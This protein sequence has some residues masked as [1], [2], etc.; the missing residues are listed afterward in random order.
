MIGIEVR[1]LAGRFHA[2]AW[3][4]AHNEGIP[5]WP[6]SP[7]RVL[8]ALVHAACM[9][10]VPRERAEPLLARISEPPRYLL[11]RAVDAHTRHYMPDVARSDHET[12]R[13]FDT[14][15][16]VEGGAKEPSPLLVA[17]PV[18]L[19]A[20]ERALLVELCASV[21]YLGRAESWA[22]LRVV[23]VAEDAAW[24]CVPEPAAAAPHATTLLAPQSATGIAEWS[25]GRPRP[26]RGADVPRSL[27]D[28][29]TFT[30]ARF[31]AEGWTD[32]PGTARVRYVFRGAP[33]LRA[34]VP[35]AGPRR[36]EDP[37][38]ACFAVRSAVLPRLTDAI[39]ICERL[40]TAAMSQSRR[41]CG[42]ARVVFSGHGQRDLEHR[43]ARYLAATSGEHEARRGRIDRLY[44]SATAG[45]APDDVIA[46]QQIRRLWGDGGHD[47]E[48]V[49]IGL[50]HAAD[51]GGLTAPRTPVLGCSRIW[52]SATPFVPVR[53]PKVRRGVEID[54]IEDQI[55]QQCLRT[56]GCEPVAITPIGRRDEWLRFHRRRT[57]GGGRR[58]PDLAV[59]ARLVFASP[60]QGP[61]ALGFGS[62]FGLGVFTAAPDDDATPV[63]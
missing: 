14:F 18:E 46:L 45:F 54:S 15:V 40:R 39:R 52:T 50:G 6:P 12:S 42:D 7:W 57:R 8:R 47:I 19:T 61:I 2:N 43:H 30:G 48:L 34:V 37:T 22:E 60:V 56:L 20:D 41:R 51:F 53:H 59:G 23:D 32:V 4:H 63:G 1:F 11:P 10:G 24:S 16:A 25:A 33:F 26:K 9:R 62:H 31:E 49:L 38:V 27:W 58:G 29:L 28:V 5:E 13:V 17:W 21:G 35:T 36:S 3:H 44:V 55:R